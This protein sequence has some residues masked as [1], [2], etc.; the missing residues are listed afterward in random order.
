MRASSPLFFLA[1]CLSALLLLLLVLPPAALA[2]PAPVFDKEVLLDG[3]AEEGSYRLIRTVVTALS[4]PSGQSGPSRAF[5]SPLLVC[6]TSGCVKAVDSKDGKD[7]G[8]A[9][10]PACASVGGGG[11]RRAR[12]FRLTATGGKAAS[13]L[14]IVTTWPGNTV[15]KN[16]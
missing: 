3:S 8:S 16:A 14:E 5:Y 4:L 1:T 6:A 7:L 9:C 12:P 13:F 15:S 11:S 2:A 10:A